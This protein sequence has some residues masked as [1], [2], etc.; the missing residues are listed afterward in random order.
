M[1]ALF[2]NRGKIK[3]QLRGVVPHL[4]DGSLSILQ[5]ADDTVGIS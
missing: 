4:V 5:I 1:L 2:I 3:D